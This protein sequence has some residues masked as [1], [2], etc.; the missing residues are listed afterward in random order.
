MESLSWRHAG[1]L[2][3]L[4]DLSTAWK[5]FPIMGMKNRLCA[6]IYNNKNNIYLPAD[7]SGMSPAALK[8]VKLK[9]RQEPASDCSYQTLRRRPV[10]V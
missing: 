5:I 1:I 10:F 8:A 7:R 4:A 2:A 9:R 3:C 6:A